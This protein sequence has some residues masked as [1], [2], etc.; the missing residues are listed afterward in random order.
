MIRAIRTF[1]WLL[2][3]WLWIRAKRIF[4]PSAGLRGIPSEIVTSEHRQKNPGYFAPRPGFV[5]NPL[6][7]YP[8]NFLCFCGSKKKAKACCIPKVKRVVPKDQADSLRKYVAY[9]AKFS[10]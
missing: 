7:T 1:L 3:R 9:R 5:S 4:L 2:P 10:Q 8:R 6:L